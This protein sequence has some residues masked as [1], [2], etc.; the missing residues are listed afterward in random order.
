[1]MEGE[2]INPPERVD[3]RWEVFA[4]TARDFLVGFMPRTVLLA[5]AA[6]AAT[7]VWIEGFRQEALERTAM[8]SVILTLGIG[9]MLI[10]NAAFVA[11][12]IYKKK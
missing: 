6:S 2:P 7:S 11:L 9:T 4:T 3:T 8:L 1:M 12:W 10:L 5:V